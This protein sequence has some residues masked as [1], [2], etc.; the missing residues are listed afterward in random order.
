MV[1]IGDEI[2]IINQ[3]GQYSLW[4]DKTWIVNSIYRSSKENPYYDDSMKGQALVECDGFCPLR[5]MNGN[6]RLLHNA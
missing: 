3:N 6:L 2:R 1:E 4:T 5:C